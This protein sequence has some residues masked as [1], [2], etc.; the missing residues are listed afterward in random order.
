MLGF[1]SEIT[2]ED[3]SLPDSTHNRSKGTQWA[4]LALVIVALLA[5]PMVVFLI[6]NRPPNIKVRVP[7]MPRD[8][9]Y[10]YF[11]R[12]GKL[13]DHRHYGPYS[14]ATKKPEQWTIPEY[15]VFL[16]ANA[17]AIAELRRGMRKPYMTPPVLD[18][19]NTTA[20]ENWA[21]FRELGRILVG[22]ALYYDVT[23]Q[24][25]KSADSHLDCVEF[26]VTIPR[27]GPL[28]AGLVGIAVE[29]IGSYRLEPVIQKLPSSDLAHVAERFER[30]QAKRMTLAE[31]IATEANESALNDASAFS[32]PEMLKDLANPTKWLKDDLTS[33]WNPN[34][35]SS[36]SAKQVWRNMR[37]AFAN[38]TAMIRQNQRY[39]KALAREQSRIYT[40]KSRV[41]VPDNPLAQLWGDTILRGAYAFCRAEA[42]TTL[43][44]TE[45]ALRGYRA[46]NG[47]YPDKLDGLVPTYLKA[48]P[49]DPFGKGKPMRYEPL[50]NGR[51]FLLYSLGQD[52]VDDGG[53]AIPLSS[54]GTSGDYVAG[55]LR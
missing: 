39:M 2:A 7:K 18:W 20:F 28:I 44:Q 47:R 33:R 50:D 40:G 23:A 30:I 5:A 9:G 17:N 51:R 10:D 19:E 25:A 45:V 46:D 37:F 32:R 12:A 53:T 15:H 16:A 26:G 38:K 6:N 42:V 8:N 24:P 4:L 55:E 48:V 52:M 14:L 31:V 41:K 49:I 13:I 22:E 35:S 34:S 43:L 36:P 3:I 11:V 29:S 21:R 54:G 1:D 27:G